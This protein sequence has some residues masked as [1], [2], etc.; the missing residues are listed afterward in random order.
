LLA[1]WVVYQTL[2]R[3]PGELMRYAER[4]LIGHNKLEAVALPVF[5]WVRPLFEREPYPLQVS[6]PRGQQAQRL[7]PQ[8][9]DAQGRPVPSQAQTGPAVAS[10][11]ATQYVQDTPGLLRAIRQAQPGDVIELAPGTYRVQTNVKIGQAGRADAPVV[12]RAER[13]G[14]SVIEFNALEGFLVQVPYWVFE[15]LTIVGKCPRHQDCEHAFHVVTKAHSTVIRNNLVEDFNAHIKVNGHEGR[16][17]DDGL[18]QFN[19]LRNSRGRDT[20]FPVTPIDVVAASRWVV[21]D[22]I[23]SDFVKLHGNLI[24]YGV[25]M[26]GAGEDG[27]IERNTIVCTSA[28]ISQPGLR[29]GA[30][31]G[32]GGTGAPFCRDK[33]CI[34]E[35]TRGVLQDNDIAHCNDFGI[36]I[37]EANQT[38]IRGNRLLNTAGIDVRFPNAS[39]TITGNVVEGRIRSR[40]GGVVQASDNQ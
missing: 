12:L 29:V 30:S 32:G 34:A 23:I 4:R 21:A 10:P 33:Q 22:N 6:A 19:T 31:F 25:F 5:A 18:V 9:Y 16:W 14:Q 1:A 35:H 20:H 17:P 38:L 8:R 15:D 13:V 37:N 27:R 26:K 24:S 2:D 7:P 39:A 28:H 40:E 36:Y 3:T 11:L